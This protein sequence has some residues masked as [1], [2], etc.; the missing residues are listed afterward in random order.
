MTP[1]A[2]GVGGEDGPEALQTLSAR[3]RALTEGVTS[4]DGRPWREHGRYEAG[5]VVLHTRHGM[6]IVE[7]VGDDGS[8]D[9]LFRGGYQ[10]L[11]TAVRSAE[12]P[13]TP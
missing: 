7:R 11:A 5:E 1:S 9:V 10:R 6:G 4:R 12:S 13:A 3:W 2:G 8:V